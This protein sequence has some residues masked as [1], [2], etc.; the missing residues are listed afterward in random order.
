MALLGWSAAGV[1]FLLLR[2]QTASLKREIE[3]SQRWGKLGWDEVARTKA[4]LLK[5]KEKADEERKRY[6]EVMAEV[7]EQAAANRRDVETLE[8]ELGPDSSAAIDS[9]RNRF[10]RLFPGSKTPDGS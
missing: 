7:R 4:A 8:R 6:A 1:V 2:E 9:V 5:L 10:A 3:S